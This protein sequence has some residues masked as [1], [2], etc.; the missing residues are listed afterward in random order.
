MITRE[1]ATKLAAE[2]L[3]KQESII[4]CEVTIVESE[5]IELPYGWVFFYNSKEFLETGDI[6][7]ALAG[8]G[9]VLVTNDTGDLVEFGTAHP[10]EQYLQH[11]EKTK[12]VL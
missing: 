10:V 8:G 3:R 9:P 7:H 6:C 11:Y 4:G 12:N 2:H 1:N 5:T